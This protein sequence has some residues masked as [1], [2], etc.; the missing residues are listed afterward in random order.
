MRLKEFLRKALIY[1]RNILLA[2]LGFAL[3][4]ALSFLFTRGFTFLAY[5][6]RILYTGLVITMIAFV[7]GLAA[8]FAGKGFGIPLLIR[9]PEEAKKLLDNFVDYR[10]LVEQRYDT[11]IQIFLVGLG[12]VVVSALVQVF[13][14]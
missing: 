11:G 10:E 5:S 12:C 8:G 2:D 3:L 9:K 14:T 6:E 7:V 1:I 4:V 13:L